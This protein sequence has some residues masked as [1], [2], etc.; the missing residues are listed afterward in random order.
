MSSP[1]DQLQLQGGA[2]D[3]RL[4]L[5]GGALGDLDAAVD[6]RDPVGELVGLVEVLRG[7]QDGAA[8]R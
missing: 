3:R 1:D 2:A 5:V 8:R 4:Q 6:D 7:Q